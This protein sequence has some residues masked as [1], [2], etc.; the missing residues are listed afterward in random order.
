MQRCIKIFEKLHHLQ[1]Q[2]KQEPE[3]TLHGSMRPMVSLF[4][5]FCENKVD[6]EDFF[7]IS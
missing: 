2:G 6:V 4:H 1:I 5:R 7:E 3:N